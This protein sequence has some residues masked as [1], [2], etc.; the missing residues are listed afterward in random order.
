MTDEQV[1]LIENLNAAF[2]PSSPIQMKDFFFGRIEQLLRV[3]EAI[4][5]IGQHIILYGERGVGKT[6]LANIVG[7]SITNIVIERTTCNRDD[8]FKSIWDRLLEGCLISYETKRIG[9]TEETNTEQVDLRAF[10][11]KKAKLSPSSVFKALKYFASLTPFPI[12]FLLDEYDRVSDLQ[13]KS[14]MAD[15]MKSISDSLPSVTIMI[16]GVS[17][18]VN[19]LIGEH[20]SL[21][22]CIKQILLPKM[23]DAEL[24]LIIE[25][26][27]KLIGV[28]I[29][30]SVEHQILQLSQGYPHYT[31]LL[32][33]YAAKAAILNGEA[34]ISSIHFDKA[35]DEAILNANESIRNLFQKA[36][37]TTK[38]TTTFEDVVYASS[39]VR[40]DEH[41]TFRAKD[42]ESPLN[43]ITNRLIVL[44]SYIYHLGKL[45]QE[46]RG[47]IYIKIGR[48]KQSRYRFRD[49]MLKAYALLKLK[50]KG[51]GENAS[52]QP[53]L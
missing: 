42:L 10:I 15:L 47:K 8:S 28:S 44:Q 5:E 2:T 6:S 24:L 40:L 34:Q 17:E 31:H 51:I 18:S 33:K 7:S 13:T 21:Q 41:S 16:V 48:P 1:R 30:P 49:P 12:L 11:P 27:L 36:V 37:I 35:L 53:F 20:E 46:E 38:G 14:Q 29:N 23:S 19:D 43:R 32:T 4:K 26:G 25:N 45:C 9:F 50:K 39:I 3:V 52:A 22:R